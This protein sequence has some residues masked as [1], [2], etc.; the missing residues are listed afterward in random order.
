[1]DNRHRITKPGAKITEEAI[2]ECAH[3]FCDHEP[4]VRVFVGVL[5]GVAVME[6]VVLGVA[7][8]D[9]EA[10][11]EFVAVGERVPVA[12]LLEEGVLEAVHV[13]DGVPEGE[14]TMPVYSPCK[15]QIRK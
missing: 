13:L 5:G 12:V 11:L 4:G 6:A 7:V 3:Q 2:L 8:E 9:T 10:V 14:G 1:M 15:E